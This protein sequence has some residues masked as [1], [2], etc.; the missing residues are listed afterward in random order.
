MTMSHFTA[1]NDDEKSDMH[2][3][4]DYCEAQIAMDMEP[5]DKRADDPEAAW[6]VEV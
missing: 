4:P 3:H 2:P 1:S 6:L 5:A